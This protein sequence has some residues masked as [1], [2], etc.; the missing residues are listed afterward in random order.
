ML[1]RI[2]FLEWLYNLFLEVLRDR[3]HPCP[4]EHP[5]A[6]R[7]RCTYSTIMARFLKQVRQ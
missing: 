6:I 3:G 4:K 5:R 7:I 2:K 1:K